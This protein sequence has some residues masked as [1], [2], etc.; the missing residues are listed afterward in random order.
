MKKIFKMGLKKDLKSFNGFY[1][2][3]IH[4]NNIPKFYI[5]ITEELWSYLLELGNFKFIGDYKKKKD[6]YTVHEKDH[7]EKIIPNSYS[8]NNIALED[9]ISAIEQA[10]LAVLLK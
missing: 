10:I 8:E 7:F 3:S 2:E 9:R 1:I 6:L 4:K 5:N